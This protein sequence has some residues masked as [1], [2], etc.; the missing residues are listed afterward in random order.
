MNSITRDDWMQALTDAEG[1]SDPDA[2]TVS[3]F[4]KM[5]N[6]NRSSAQRRLA[7]LIERGKAT[8]TTKLVADASGR[9]Q[10]HTAYAL[11]KEVPKPKDATKAKR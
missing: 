8:R 3:E 11:V 1:A 7:L 9:R 4:A 5:A 6:L 2:I 10:R